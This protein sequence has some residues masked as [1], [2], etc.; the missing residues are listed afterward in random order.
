MMNANDNPENPLPILTEI[1][2]QSIHSYFNTYFLVKNYVTAET[3]I[4][5]TR[6]TCVLLTFVR[7]TISN[8]DK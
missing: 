5:Y 4:Y 3:L 8:S 2:V 6:S 1:L 7:A